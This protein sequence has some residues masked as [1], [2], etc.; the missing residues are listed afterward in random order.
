MHH[1]QFLIDLAKIALQR[2]S[3]FIEG[4]LVALHVLKMT[5]ILSEQ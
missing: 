5:K 3:R 2:I 4:N 1:R